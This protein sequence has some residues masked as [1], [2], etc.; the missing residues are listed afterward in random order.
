MRIR[1][2]PHPFLTYPHIWETGLLQSLYPVDPPT[3]R[4]WN[5]YVVPGKSPAIA[6]NRELVYEPACCQGPGTLPAPTTADRTS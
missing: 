6:I 4:T 1:E 5:T 3:A 2:N